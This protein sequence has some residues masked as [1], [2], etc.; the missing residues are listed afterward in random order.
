MILGSKLACMFLFANLQRIRCDLIRNLIFFFHLAVVVGNFS[1]VASKV[2][3]LHS[4]TKISSVGV[5]W[6][7]DHDV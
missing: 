4:I 3:I 5:V 2:P 1:Y 7:N 6:L